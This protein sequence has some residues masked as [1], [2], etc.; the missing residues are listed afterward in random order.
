MKINDYRQISSQY[1]SLDNTGTAYLAFKDVPTLIKK[2][3]KGNLTLD[4]GCGSGHSTL[5]LNEIGLDVRGVDISSEMLNE[6][7]KASQSIPFLLIE[8]A[9][10]P[11]ND[12]TFD[13]VFS[14]F[15]L[16]EISNKNELTR[17][18]NE[19]YRV[20]KKN[21]IFIAITGSE[22]LY[23]HDWLS[24]QVDF[25]ENKKLHSGDIAKVYLKDAD[26]AV[27][28]YFWTDQDYKDA[29]SFTQFTLVEKLLPLGDASDG[30]DWLDENTYPP[31]VMYVLSKT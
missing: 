2:Y 24:L 23:N 15:V 26:L 14:S 16:F 27:Y 31:Y 4:Y 18:F 12:N 10:L 9:K 5:F 22:E 13:V 17:I 29:L 3:A 6:A 20:L 1:A 7:M 25:P 28:D 30:Y 8:S 19:I 11:F 21:G